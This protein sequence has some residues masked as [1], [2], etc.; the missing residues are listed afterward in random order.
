MIP[1]HRSL[2]AS[3]IASATSGSHVGKRP[4]RGADDTELQTE[5]IRLRR[6]MKEAVENEDYEK[7]SELRDRI[8]S[9]EGD[10]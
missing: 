1:G 3:T 6:V 5:M 4:K 8:R 10:S 9:L 2:M 7:A